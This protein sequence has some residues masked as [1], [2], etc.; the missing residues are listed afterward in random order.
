[1]PLPFCLSKAVGVP[2]LIII[3]YILQSYYLPA[4]TIILIGFNYHEA[5]GKSIILDPQLP[6]L[7]ICKYF[8]AFWLNFM[9]GGDGSMGPL[10]LIRQEIEGG[11]HG[12]GLRQQKLDDKADR[13]MDVGRY[14][15]MQVE[16]FDFVKNSICREA[17]LA[18]H[19][20]PI[21][22]Q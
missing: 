16:G 13:Q 15:Q 1:M 3:A 17:C 2:R 18:H 6:K 19:T 22:I 7:L 10:K 12:L 9:L 21:L 20:M 8:P 4:L 11:V 14:Q 5:L